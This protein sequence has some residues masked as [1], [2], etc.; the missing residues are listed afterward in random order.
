MIYNE[1][2]TFEEFM[3]FARRFEKEFNEWVQTK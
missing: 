1:V 2:P 3:D